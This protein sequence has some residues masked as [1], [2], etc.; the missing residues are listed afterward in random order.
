V[1]YGSYTDAS[2]RLLI[3]LANS[4]DPR[5]DPPEQLPDI[6]AVT[7][8]LHRHRMLGPNTVHQRDVTEL[9]HLRARLRRVFEA[10]DEAAALAE[11]NGLLAG[12]GVTPWIARTPAGREIFFAPQDA[13]LARRVT[14]DAGL[15][16]AMMMV[17]HTDRL[18]ICAAAD[19]AN[20]FVDESRNR[21]RRWCSARCSGRI[22]VAAFRTRQKAE[23]TAPV[24]RPSKPHPGKAEPAAPRQGRTTARR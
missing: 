16:L 24:G 10:G 23:P 7:G 11:L 19:C 5:Q 18:K 14:C 6:A 1:D 8:F 15:G 3:E 17:D 4:H 12:A 22:N 13:P 9:H 21:S 20:V 2:V